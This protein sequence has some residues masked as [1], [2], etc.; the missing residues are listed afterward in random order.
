MLKWTYDSQFW[1]SKVVNKIT[2]AGNTAH[3]I[4]KPWTKSDSSSTILQGPLPSLFFQTVI[5]SISQTVQ[6]MLAQN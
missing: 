3:T 4:S 6:P 2:E 5:N 1:Q